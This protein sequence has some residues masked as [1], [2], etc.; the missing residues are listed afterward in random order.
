MDE[1]LKGLLQF[2]K[3]YGYQESQ[4]GYFSNCHL[5]AD[6]RKF[7]ATKGDFKGLTPKEF[8]EYLG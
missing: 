3:D 4:T 2:A 8:Y 5:Y 1:D 7:L 6:S